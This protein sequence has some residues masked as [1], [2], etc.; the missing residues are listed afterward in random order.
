M[1]SQECVRS[2][3]IDWK[4]LE[5]VCY[6]AKFFNKKIVFTNGCFD[7]LHRGHIEYLHQAAEMGDWL[8]VGLNTDASVRR[9]KGNG[10]PVQDEE[11]RALILASL[12]CVNYV[13][14]FDEDTPLK[15][16]QLVQPDI[17]VKGGDYPDVEKIV[18]YDVVKQRGGKV[19]ALPFVEGHSTT[20]LL[21][22]IQQL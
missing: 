6:R 7:I 10:R 9:L 20:Q 22:K 11:T 21:Q 12:S 16:I 4:E 1:N 2:K 5:R 18:G 17:L 8:I 15:I 3:I 19:I 14:L 13:V